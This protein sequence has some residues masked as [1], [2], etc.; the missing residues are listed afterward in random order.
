MVV[1]SIPILSSMVDVYV[2]VL[3][4]STLLLTHVVAF[5]FGSLHGARDSKEEIELLER[6]VTRLTN[7]NQRMLSKQ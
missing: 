5:Y 4:G 3:A 7:Q 2:L 6:Q 1:G